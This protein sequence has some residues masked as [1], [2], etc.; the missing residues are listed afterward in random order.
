MFNDPVRRIMTD[1]YPHV[2]TDHCGRYITAEYRNCKQDCVYKIR[3]L[4]ILPGIFQF[5]HECLLWTA[6]IFTFETFER[7]MGICRHSSY[8]H[9]L[10]M[11]VVSAVYLMSACPAA[12]TDAGIGSRSQEDMDAASIIIDGKILFRI[13]FQHVSEEELLN[14]YVFS[15][16]QDRF[17]VSDR[18]HH[19]SHGLKP[20]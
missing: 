4:L 19:F 7:Y 8:R 13:N 12:G 20:F 11:P 10:R 15:T 18:D 2:S 5:F 3:T 9:P 17:S 6:F 14:R 1:H 16:A